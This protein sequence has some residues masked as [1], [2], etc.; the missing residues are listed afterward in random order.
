MP[1]PTITTLNP[2]SG[3][4]V[5]G[6]PVMI[7]G[8]NFTNPAV[9]SVTL[10]GTA[11]SFTIQSDILL[12]VTVPPGVL[13][14]ATVT[15][16]NGSG[17][18]STTYVYRPGL[19]LS[20]NRGPIAGGTT[21]DIFGIGL[22]G[23]EEVVFGDRMAS[24]TQI[25]GTRIQATSPPSLGSVPV[26]VDTPGGTAGPEAYYYL[27]PPFKSRISP[28]GGPLAGGTA[29]TITGTNLLGV[30]SV[31][32]GGTGGSIVAN[33]ASS[34]TAATPSRA[35]TGNV[36]VVVTTPGGTTDGLTFT[37][38]AQPTL[39][40]INPGAGTSAGGQAVTINGTNLA[41]TTQV[42]FGGI[43]SPSFAIVNNTRIISITPGGPAGTVD[44]VVT[45]AAGSATLVNG[46]R[47]T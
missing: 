22:S 42:T 47:Y 38:A 41:T 11:A 5:G 20:P 8:T 21:V 31:S 32:F 17:S 13:G 26:T 36:S 40:S 15:V 25:S 37:Y 19:S 30:S 9:T 33:T 24:F 1:A 18:A 6:Y 46:Y 2:S 43:A 10:G 39:T 44:V 12:T 4:R 45:T 29:I 23:A 27:Y 14:P 34:V 28:T 3:A 16:T 7:R 35:S